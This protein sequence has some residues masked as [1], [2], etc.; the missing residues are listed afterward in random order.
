LKFD[1]SAFDRHPVLATY[2]RVATPATVRAGGVTR[3]PNVARRYLRRAEHPWFDHVGP[4]QLLYTQQKRTRLGAKVRCGVLD[5]LTRLSDQ[6][7]G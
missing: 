1:Q 6:V 7:M 3:Q 2:S 5:E 4:K